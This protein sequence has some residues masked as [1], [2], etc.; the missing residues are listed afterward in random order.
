MVVGWWKLM[1][2]RKRPTHRRLEA[3]PRRQVQYR[4]IILEEMDLRAVVA[5]RPEVALVDELAHTNVPGSNND[6]N[7]TR[8]SRTSWPRAFMLSAPSMSSIWKA[9][10][11]S[12][13]RQ[14]G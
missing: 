2:G 6:Q 10:M 7:A 1:G 8:M 13:R 3:V 9:S 4:G 11:T 14:S 12:W 5:R